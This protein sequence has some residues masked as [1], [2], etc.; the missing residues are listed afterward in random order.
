AILAVAAAL[1]TPANA[2]VGGDLADALEY[3]RVVEVAK[4]VAREAE[5]QMQ[6]R[7]E[8]IAWPHRFT[9]E[10]YL[11]HTDFAIAIRSRANVQILDA[12]HAILK[13]HSHSSLLLSLIGWPATSPN[14]AATTNP[15]GLVVTS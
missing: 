14:V 2:V 12:R 10:R 11:T 13:S 6:A 8:T 15:W 5:T 3:L 7:P 9:I 4:N 1:Q